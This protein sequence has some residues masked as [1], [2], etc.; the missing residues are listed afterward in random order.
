MD[1]GQPVTIA[2]KIREPTGMTE[3]LERLDNSPSMNWTMKKLRLAATKIQLDGRSKMTKAEL[4]SALSSK[5]AL[6]DF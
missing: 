1:G 2:A 3:H 6:F 5:T 4:V